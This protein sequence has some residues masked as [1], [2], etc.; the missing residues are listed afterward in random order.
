[1]ESLGKSR[2]NNYFCLGGGLK[3]GQLG[4]GRK[5]SNST[6]IKAIGGKREQFE[7][8][9]IGEKIAIQLEKFSDLLFISLHMSALLHLNFG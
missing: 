8:R 4:T 7:K 9:E 5:D 1:M 2:K 3:P 6:I